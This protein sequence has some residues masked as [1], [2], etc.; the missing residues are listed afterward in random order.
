MKTSA[1]QATQRRDAIAFADMLT[2][3]KLV[4][5]VSRSRTALEQRAQQKPRRGNIVQLHF[6]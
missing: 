6:N 3:A 2:Q 1:F 4:D 5:A